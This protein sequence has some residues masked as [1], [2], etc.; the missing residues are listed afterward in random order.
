MKV[1][2][3]AHSF[4][5]YPTDPV[6]S[7]VLRLA[8]ALADEGVEVRVIA[9]GAPGLPAREE[10]ERVPVERFRYA[11]RRYETLAYTG[12]MRAQVRES[13]SSRLTLAGFVAAGVARAVALSRRFRPDLVHAHWWFPGGLVAVWSRSFT[14]MPVVTTIHG[15]DLRLARNSPRTAALCRWVLRRSAA[16]T[17]VSRWLARETVAIAPHTQPL[18]A[19]MPVQPD[20]FFPG[21]ERPPNRLLFVGKLNAQK[22]IHH[23]FRALALMR[24]PATLDV[25]VGVGSTPAGVEPLARELGVADRL[26]WHPLLEQAALA[27]LYRECTALVVPAVDEGLGLTAVEA[28]LCET[29][30]VA[31][32]SGGLTDSV[33]HGRTGLLVP[34]GDVAALASA[35]DQLVGRPDH[36]AALGQAGRRHALATFSPAAV[37]QRYVGVYRDVLVKGR[38]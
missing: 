1:L 12:T 38:T 18:V 21:A 29:P 34:P 3:F 25:V 27:Q 5:R 33:I 37:A 24:A 17:T 23:L 22:G 28:L 26:R 13:W 14:S 11:P 16:V 10:F 6:G 4:P 35:L 32:E 15:S 2:F 36:G 31:F 20:L 9:P 8:V 19:P 7:F 30:V